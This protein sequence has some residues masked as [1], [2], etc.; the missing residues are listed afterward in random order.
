MNIYKIT[1]LALLATL[2]VVGRI[3]VN[4]IPN[5][6]PVTSVIIISGIFLG[7]IAGFILAFLV[8]FLSNMIL[9]TGIWTIWQILAW[10]IIGIL[11]GL[12]GKAFKKIPFI[13]IVIFSFFSGYLYGIIVS[14]TNYQVTG[15]GF[16]VYYLAGLPFDTYHAIGNAVF[17]M[18]L[19]PTIAYVFKKYINNHLHT[20]N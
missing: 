5:V 6:Q 15:Q 20:I 8:T 14:L 9:G 4:Y 10:G 3:A 16:I 1:L 17:M 7:P 13:V 11:S 19:Y 12:M 2:A 18:L